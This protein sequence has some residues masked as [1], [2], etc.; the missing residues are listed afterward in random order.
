MIDT[1]LPFTDTAKH[2]IY[3]LDNSQCSIKRDMK[4]KRAIAK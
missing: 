4:V 1:D 3:F 2:G